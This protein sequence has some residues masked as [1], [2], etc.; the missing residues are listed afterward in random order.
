MKISIGLMLLCIFAGSYAMDSREVVEVKGIVGQGII[1]GNVS[2]LEARRQALNEAKVEALRKAGVS[3]HLQSYDML[4][5]SEV[6][7]DYSEFFSSDIQSELQGAVQHYEIVKEERKLDSATN[8]FVYEITID[9]RV[10]KYSVR[11]DPL[12]DAIITGIKGVYENEEKLVF[13]VRSTRDCYLNIFNIT[14]NSTTLMYPNPWE[15]E[16]VIKAGEQINFPFGQVDYYLEKSSSVPENNRLIFVFTKE[17]MKYLS[18]T[19]EDQITTAEQIFSWIY[20]I[21]PDRRKVDYHTF[22]IR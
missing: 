7:M 14:D 15:Q 22:F 2:E 4:F 1:A 16:K 5:R 9:A 8:L 3:E 17:P 13:A 18:F 20:S 12:F 21:T 19:G 6:N 10:V 11:P